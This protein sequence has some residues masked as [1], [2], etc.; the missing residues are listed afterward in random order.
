MPKFRYKA[1]D[2]AGKTR[3]STVIAFSEANAEEKLL[4]K[5]LTVI[6]SEPAKENS[7]AG[8]F[9]SRRVKPRELVE[10]YYRLSQTLELGLPML[11]A[12]E[13][14]EKI[15]PTPFFRK[16]IEEIRMSI[17]AGN[18]LYE[19]MLQYPR[20]FEPLD[21]AIVRLGEES[22]VLPGSL[23]ELAEFI[24]WKEDIR[25]TLKRA[26]IYPSFIILAIV[27]V[28][29]VWVGYVL[30]QMANLLTEMGVAL[31]GV[32]RIVL[33]VSHFVQNYWLWLLGG[34]LIV[35]FLAYLYTKTPRGK[36][37]FHKYMLK[38]PLFGSILNNIAI[39]RLSHNFAT[40]YTAGMSI[41]NIFEILSDRILG[42]RYLESLLTIAFEDIQ[43]GESISD[44][45]EATAGFP[46]LLIGAIRNGE[47]TGTIDDA[48]RRLGTYYD[49]EVKRNVDTMI[50]ALEP[51]S[52]IILGGIFGLIALSI[53]LPLY[54]MISEIQ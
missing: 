3:R 13:E 27:A 14:N 26:A 38:I 7:L 31:P 25:S 51:L 24:E 17:E 11:S 48:F 47:T 52:I 41:N 5:G 37:Q 9:I 43:R 39:A 29:S 42:N 35:G 45:M 19:S 6:H 44:A 21:L 1:I 53:M 22:G 46:T 23:R 54:D 10:F 36:I 34:V 2:A 49:K 32:T 20:V 8:F 18:T 30:P 12:L 50:N 4:E 28:I 40:M 15:I 33:N 16:I